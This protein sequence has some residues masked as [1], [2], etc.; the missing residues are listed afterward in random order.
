[1]VDFFFFFFFCI[2]SDHMLYMYAVR[3]FPCPGNFLL[4]G[5]FQFFVIELNKREEMG[6]VSDCHQ[7]F[8]CVG[9][10]VV[11]VLYPSHS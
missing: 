10:S 8:V 1:M 3:L 7:Q 5:C 9:L 11:A 6:S 4:Y 2:Y